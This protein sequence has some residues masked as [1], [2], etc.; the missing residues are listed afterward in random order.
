[1]DQIVEG[2]ELVLSDRSKFVERSIGFAVG[3]GH[4]GK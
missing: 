3:P 2:E 1:M 4:F